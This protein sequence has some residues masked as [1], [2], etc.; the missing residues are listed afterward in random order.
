MSMNAK[1]NT[2]EGVIT[3]NSAQERGSTPR[4]G[5]SGS[6]EVGTAV[7]RGRY[8]VLLGRRVRCLAGS[9]S[10]EVPVRIVRPEHAPRPTRPEPSISLQAGHDCI[11]E[12]WEGLCYTAL[13][14]CGL[15][16]IALCFR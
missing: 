8:G 2:I 13:G 6:R 3:R 5:L 7:T 16:V 1:R 10:Y 15:V 11:G 9:I 4:R 12:F 14:L